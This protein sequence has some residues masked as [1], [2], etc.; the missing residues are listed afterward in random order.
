MFITIF[1]KWHFITIT[2]LAISILTFYL[3]NTPLP[4][5]EEYKCPAC[6]ETDLCPE[7]YSGEITITS[8]NLT[9]KFANLFSIKNT[10]FADWYQEINEKTKKVVIKKLAHSSQLSDFDEQICKYMDVDLNKCDVSKLD[11]SDSDYLMDLEDVLVLKEFG[12][13][14]DVKAME[15]SVM[16]SILC[17]G[18]DMSMF[19]DNIGA[20][21]LNIFVWYTLHINPE[22]IILQVK[23]KSSAGIY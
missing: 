15:K 3:I 9:E 17:T 4:D 23:K 21:V 22:P 14:D 2:V 5:L 1:L 8:D 11:F 6:Y 12:K 10:M 16:S 19:L 13:V 7:F 18:S 20:N